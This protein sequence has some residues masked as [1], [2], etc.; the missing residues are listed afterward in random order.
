VFRIDG[1]GKVFASRGIPRPFHPNKSKNFPFY[2]R[3]N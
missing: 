1:L 3:F 2:L